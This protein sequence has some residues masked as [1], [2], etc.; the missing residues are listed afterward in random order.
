M[1]GLLI[2]VECY[3]L[4]IQ[5]CRNFAGMLMYREGYFFYCYSISSSGAI[6]NPRTPE[7]FLL[8]L[9]IQSVLPVRVTT[10]ITRIDRALYVR[11]WSGKFSRAR[12]R[13]TDSQWAK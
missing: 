2:S 5:D 1:A 11:K 8:H 10:V 6:S 4:T 3:N 7:N 13:T 12:N 9:R